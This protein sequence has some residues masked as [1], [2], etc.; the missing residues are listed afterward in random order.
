MCARSG[1]I[2]MSE[3]VLNLVEKLDD[4]KVFDADWSL[5]EVSVITPPRM[6]THTVGGEVRYE[7]GFVSTITLVLDRRFSDGE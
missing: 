3:K 2:P 6:L 7:P 5:R 4:L 1:M